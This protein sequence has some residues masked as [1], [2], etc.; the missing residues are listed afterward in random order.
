MNQ[1]VEWDMYDKYNYLIHYIRYR[2]NQIIKKF[3][4]V[5]YWAMPRIVDGKVLISTAKTNDI[6]GKA[7]MSGKPFWCG[8]FGGVENDMI[9][10]VLQH[11]I[12]PEKDVRQ[13]ALE[14]LY[15]NAGFFPKDMRLAEKFV[16]LMI[17]NCKDIDVQGA[18]R[19]YME[20]YLHHKYQKNTVLSQLYH[21]EPWNMYLYKNSK[22]KP[23]SSCLKGKK[24]L[25]IHPFAE[26]IEK[27]YR[28]N[29]EKIFSNIFDADDIL[30]VFELK[31][32]KAVQTQCDE[33]D[34]RFKDWFEALQWMK[35]EAER[36]EFDVAI[37][38]CG[39]Y[40]FPLAAHIKR[41]GKVAIHLGGATQLLFGILGARWE[42]E[43]PKFCQE[44]V[45]EYWVRPSATEK[46]SDSNKIE[47]SCYW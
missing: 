45:N 16:D 28:E 19:R 32:I 1:R 39:A 47:D 46:I 13:E 3:F 2:K 12:Y 43:N 27:Q 37:I 30:P 23:W 14:M 10:A 31:V 25:V 7:I 21:L 26:S 34:E 17:D 18:W 35:E 44:V 4:G 36:T 9:H 41:M 33:Q 20:D 15:Y 29:R 11:R 22:V 40:G 42:R 6:I 38:G 24:V 8:R 5:D